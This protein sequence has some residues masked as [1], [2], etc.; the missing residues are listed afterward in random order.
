M[1]KIISVVGARPNF[2]KVSPV[3][4]E[5]LKSKDVISKIVHTGQHYDEKMSQVFFEQLE[6]PKPDYYLGAKG[7]SPTALTA[8]IMV[9][10]EEVLE[11][12]KPDLVLVAGD[13]TSTLAC[14]LAA[15]QRKI[16][17]GHIESGLRSFDRDMPEEINRLLTDAVS[18]YLFVSEPAGMVNLQNEGVPADKIFHVGNCMIDSVVYYR[19][20][21]AAIDITA[22]FDVKPGEYIV[23]TMHRPSN[24]DD[25]VGLKKILEILTVLSGYRK[26]I[27]PLH[28]RTANNLQKYDLMDTLKSI[29]N[30]LLTE[31]LGYLEFMALLKDCSCVL[32]DS[33]G[34]QEETTY[35][36]VPCVTFRENTERPVTCEIGT[37][38]L[39]RE[40]DVEKTIAYVKE[41]ISKK[42]GQ[43][44]HRIPE[45]WDG[46]AAERIVDVIRQVLV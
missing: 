6:L 26:I 12:E 35:L 24:V 20:K 45:M 4:R 13:V 7:N 29:T 36:G 38:F 22:Q 34:I 19:D 28:P 40:L 16:R 42:G 31:P 2:M 23:V 32:T 3:H 44:T 25:P 10:F 33:G 21:I 46:K 37:N 1:K 15:V 41:L 39:M 43:S 9:S 17:V 18:D 11:L 27:L 14:T 8:N 5:L 30:I